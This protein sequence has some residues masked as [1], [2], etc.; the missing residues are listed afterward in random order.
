MTTDP[1]DPAVDP[2]TVAG[3]ENSQTPES[4]DEHGVEAQGE[5]FMAEDNAD[6]RIAALEEG[7]HTISTLEAEVA[8]LKDKLLR[9]AAELENT[10]KRAIRDKEDA[11]KFAA[12]KFARDIIPVADNLRR[13]IE[14][15]TDEAREAADDA[16]KNLIVG[17][18]MT[19]RELLSIFER[20]NIKKIEALG[21]KFDPNLHNAMF[22]MEDTSVPAGTVVQEIAAGFTIGERL[23]RPAQVGVARGGPAAA[24]APSDAP[25]QEA[26]KPDEKEG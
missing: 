3:T 11:Q 19:E 23:L 18:E 8:E 7:A 22:E 5:A 21:Q 1:R 14:T 4:G 20:H 10:R 15:L 25:A 26:E 2:E 16:V 13:A 17:V 12:S 6:E 9:T 24:A